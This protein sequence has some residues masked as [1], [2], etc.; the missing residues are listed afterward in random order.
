MRYTKF[1]KVV[2]AI[3]LVVVLFVCLLAL[4]SGHNVPAKTYYGYALISLVLTLLV[5]LFTY[6]DR[7]AN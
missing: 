2:F 6:L 1:F 3:L 4:G 5:V 7:K